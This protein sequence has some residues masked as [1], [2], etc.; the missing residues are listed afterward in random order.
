M[1]LPERWTLL[2]PGPVTFDPVTGN[3]IPTTPIA[4]PWRGLLQV[5]VITDETVLEEIE[6][7]H[8]SSRLT[9]LLDPGLPGGTGRRDIWRFDGP[10]SVADL[11]EVGHTVTVYGTP[12]ARRPAI[13]SRRPAYIAATVRH[14]TDY[15]ETPP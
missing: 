3:R 5:R 1:S 6:D 11:I 7:G 9:L 14:S 12:R 13:G 15:Q 2:R 8:V 4:V 10:A